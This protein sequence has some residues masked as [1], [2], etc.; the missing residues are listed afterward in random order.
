MKLEKKRYDDI[1][2]LRFTGEFDTFNL[3]GLRERINRMI[4][5]GDVPFVLDL[6]L[7]KFVNSAALG[8]LVKTSKTL[9]DKGGEAVIARPSRFMQKALVTLGLTSLC[10]GLLVNTAT[11]TAPLL[12][13]LLST[14]CFAAA[15]PVYCKT[16][17][18]RSNYLLYVCWSDCQ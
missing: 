14:V 16:Y 8:Y 12:L 17:C 6:H 10:T 15:M 4:D 3:P 18:Q 13:L 5:G 9:K 2:I 7:L 11:V 1:V